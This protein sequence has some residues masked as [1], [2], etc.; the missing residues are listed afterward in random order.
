MPL[1][2]RKATDRL[3]RGPYREDNV[4]VNCIRATGSRSFNVLTRILKISDISNQDAVQAALIEA[5]SV[6]AGGGLVAIPTETVYGL[7]ADATNDRACARIF[8]V[9][10]RP[11][12][13][14]LICHVADL[15]AALDYGLF[16]DLA[17]RLA[18]RFWPGPLTLVVPKG[19]RCNTCDLVSAGLDTL[20]LRVPD[21]P[22]VRQLCTMLGA[23][24]A[25]PS[26]NRSGHVSPTSGHDVVEDLDEDVDLILDTG[27]TPIG[28]E[29]TIVAVDGDTAIL[30]RP[31]GL[32][33]ADIEA[34]IGAPLDRPESVADRPQA[35]GMLAS[36]YAP[37]APVRLNVTEVDVGEA[38]LTFGDGP[39]AGFDHAIAVRHLSRGGDLVEAA[40]NLFRYLRELDT[41]RPVCIAVQPIPAHGLGEAINDRLT[42]AA[43]PRIVPD[44]V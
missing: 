15:D 26:A 22:L 43:A 33:S 2:E 19:G 24:I 25:A 42:R 14:P 28:L 35:P 17:R 9:K 44:S 30:L 4:H 11:T 5:R 1:C 34:V 23:P 10:G 18:A 27:P 40:A 38:L 36:H 3:C 37:Y 8:Q 31:G 12:F 32:P 7:A 21:T 29:S 41:H 13:N 6:L 39:V 16:S 20:A